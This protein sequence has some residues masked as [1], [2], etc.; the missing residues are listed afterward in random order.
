[1]F[2]EIIDDA[3]RIEHQVGESVLI[4]RRISADDHAAIMRR[5]T[6]RIRDR[7]GAWV[8]EIDETA[9]LRDMVGHVITDWQNVRHPVTKQD[10]P[11]TSENKRLLPVGIMTEIMEVLESASSA[12]AEEVEGELKNS[13]GSSA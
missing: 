13:N 6:K 5:H 9:V 10:V 2:I 8:R 4:L 3:E 7:A 12:S 1:M 11:C